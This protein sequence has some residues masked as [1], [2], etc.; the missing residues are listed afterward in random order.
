[1]LG[2]SHKSL[3]D[4]LDLHQN[5]LHA[6]QQAISTRDLNIIEDILKQKDESLQILINAQQTSTEN[7]PPE[8]ES[9]ISSI[10]DQQKKNTLNFRKLHIQE[11]RTKDGVAETNPIFKRMRKAYFN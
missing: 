5:L 9:R 4:A 3:L 7:Y 11:N 6:E 10:L 8:I 1:M 2:H